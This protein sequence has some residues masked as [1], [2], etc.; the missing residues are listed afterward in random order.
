MRQRVKITNI[1]R[2]HHVRVAT[3]KISWIKARVLVLGQAL[4]CFLCGYISMALDSVNVKTRLYI[5]CLEY[6]F[7]HTIKYDP[8]LK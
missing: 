2:T 3:A 8:N 7:K 4:I 1:L 5:T 6:F